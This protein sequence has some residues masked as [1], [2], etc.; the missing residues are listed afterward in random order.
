MFATHAHLIDRVPYL[1]QRPIPPVRIPPMTRKH[2][3]GVDSTIAVLRALTGLG[4]DARSADVALRAGVSR[5]SFHRITSE[6]AAA[7]I[8]ERVRGRV[9]VGSTGD[10]L[11]AA[12]LERSRSEDLGKMRKRRVNGHHITAVTGWAASGGGPVDLTPPPLRRRFDRLRIGF[13]NASLDNAWRIGLVHSIEHAAATFADH[14]SRFVV[15]HAGGDP[16]RQA[17]DVDQMVSEG[18]DGLIVSASAGNRPIGDAVAH[19]VERGVATVIVDRGI[20]RSIPYTSLVTADDALIGH[21]MA[22]W[23]AEKLGG[24]GS[25]LLLPGLEGTEPAHERLAAALSVFADFPRIRILAIDWTGWQRDAAYRAVASH[26]RARKPPVA[27]VWSDSGLQGIGSMQAFVDAGFG[28][29]EIPPHTGGD[30]NQ[31]YK[32]SIR[33]KTPLAAVDFPPAMGIVAFETLLSSLAGEWVAREVDVP[34]DVILTRGAATRSVQPTIWAED[35]V[36]WDLPDDLV[37][38]TGLGPHYNPHSFR[39][40]YP[41]NR[42]NRSAAG[43]DNSELRR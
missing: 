24:Q 16:T 25:I 9:R 39:V 17:H 14:I 33:S 4:G 18:L 42:Y 2:K 6:L 26:L 29:G 13:S 34:L 43:L 22:L 40:H 38:A 20:D 28:P 31:A 35:H 5:A 3:H 27:G 7:G 12:S 10:L 11:V 30:L 21:I 15:R 32:L 8:L 23:L 37:L 36:R 41:G 1:R 19:A